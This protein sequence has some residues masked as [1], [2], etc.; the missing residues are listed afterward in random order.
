M[1]KVLALA[2]C[3]EDPEHLAEPMMGAL[4]PLGR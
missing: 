1:N 4:D 2:F 3:V